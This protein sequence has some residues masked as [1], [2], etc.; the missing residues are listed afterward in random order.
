MEGKEEREVKS[1]YGERGGIGTGTEKGIEE[2]DK[3]AQG[4][5]AGTHCI[6]T[7]SGLYCGIHSRNK[8]SVLLSKKMIAST[9]A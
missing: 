3:S 6:V 2:Q 4:V 1:G 8:K 7:V 9:L 5:P